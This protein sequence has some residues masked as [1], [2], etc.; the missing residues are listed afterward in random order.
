MIKKSNLQLKNSVCLLIYNRF[1]SL[2][3]IGILFLSV[4]CHLK[5]ASFLS[6]PE[7]IQEA[8]SKS[9]E[10]LL[11]KEKEKRFTAVKRE[12]WSGA[13]PEFSLSASAG[14][15]G[16]ALDPSSFPIPGGGGALD[17]FNIEQDRYS[18]A[19]QVTQPVFTF[20][21]LGQA[22]KIA[23]LQ[24]RADKASRWRSKQLLQ[25]QVVDVFYG[26]VTA[27]ARLGILEASIKRQ[28]ETVS[29]L[30][31]NFRLGAGLRSNV[32]LAVSALK[33]L[34]P[35]RIRAE[36]DAEA[37]RMILNRLLGRPIDAPVNPET[38]TRLE[39]V[40]MVAVPDSQMIQT[41]LNGRPD[42]QSLLLQ[43]KSLESTARFFKMLYLPALG[44]QAR[45]GITAFEPE[46][47]NDLEKNREWQV[48]LGLSWTLFDGLGK[49]AKAQQ[50]ASDARS[51]ALAERQM[52]KLL[53]IEIQSAYR[54][55]EA[56]DTALSAAQ[57]SF[58]AAQEAQTL[59]SEEFRAGKGQLTDLLAAEQGLLE[60]EFGVLAARYQQIRSQAALQ[61][62]LGKDLIKEEGP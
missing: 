34:E 31:T 48:G 9:E 35:Q 39:L 6:L 45:W 41:I 11:L 2:L 54:E 21:R 37:A 26:V 57:Q 27:R 56:A 19:I 28:R 17:I 38:K 30:E 42:L 47:L 49:L 50:F 25:L 18:Y 52:R 53:H 16:M 10:V 13:F 15:G 62:A 12:A 36:R 40:R 5:A 29:F 59:L 20:G 58:K 24:D 60:A 55:Y 7:A 22:I 61:V 4:D 1:F 43:K 44:A 32:L 3:L 14:R 46:Q 23:G 8:L 33:A 51:I